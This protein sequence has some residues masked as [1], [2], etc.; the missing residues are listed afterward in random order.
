MGGGG[1]G[2]KERRRR[3]EERKEGRDCQLFH[4]LENKGHVRQGKARHGRRE[5]STE[6]TTVERK[7]GRQGTKE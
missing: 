4:G 6:D 5:A 7:E 2:R 1:K 3:K